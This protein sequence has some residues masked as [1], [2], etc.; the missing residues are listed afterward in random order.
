MKKR[1][2]FDETVNIETDKLYV[3]IHD[4]KI[5]EYHGYDLTTVFVA[6]I[7]PNGNIKKSDLDFKLFELDDNFTLKKVGRY[8]R[9]KGKIKA[10][11]QIDSHQLMQLTMKD[12]YIRL[13]FIEKF[14]IDFKKKETI[15]HQMKF[16]QRF[17]V[18]L[19]ISLPLLFIGYFINNSDFLSKNQIHKNSSTVISDNKTEI[20]KIVKIK[21][22]A[23]TFFIPDN[24]TLDSIGSNASDTGFDEVSS[25]FNFYANKIIRLYK[26]SSLNISIENNP[27]LMV[28]D[29]VIN[30]FELPL[31]YGIILSKDNFHYVETGVFSDIDIKQMIDEFNNK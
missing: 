4:G 7:L 2:Y 19:L 22:P 23:I 12:V 1:L 5:R 8:D 11:Y 24:E 25:D 20:L 14:L 16:K 10:K 6:F 17:I 18:F 29:T 27:L 9:K 26:D 3:I 31:P 15:F 21:T 30:I 13:N 28:N